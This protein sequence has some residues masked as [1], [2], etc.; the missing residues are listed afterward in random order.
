MRDKIIKAIQDTLDAKKG[1]SY[2][3][4]LSTV[5]IRAIMDAFLIG[6]DEDLT[7]TVTQHFMKKYGVLN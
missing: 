4:G 3:E 7:W 6:F 5:Q 2:V 1:I